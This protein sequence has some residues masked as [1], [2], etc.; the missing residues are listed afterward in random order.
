MKPN[1]KNSVETQIQYR[2][3]EKLNQANDKLK[4]EIKIRKKSER[5]LRQSEKNLQDLAKFPEENPNP[6]IRISTSGKILYANKSSK[7]LFDCWGCKTGDNCPDFLAEDLLK[8][9]GLGAQFEREI[10]V[11]DRYYSIEFAP[12]AND[13][14]VN[15][16]G[17]DISE[18]KLAEDAL[19][20]N[21]IKFRQLVEEANDIIYR[22][23]LRGTF[24]YIN[25]VA[26]HLMQID[27]KHVGK[28][29]YT[30]LIREDWKK[31]IE[32]F[33]IKQIEEDIPTTYFEFPASNMLGDQV[34]I[35]QN[36][37]I[38]K[39]RGKTTGLQAV[40]R[41]IT[42]RKNLEK[43]LKSINSFSAV[44]LK[45]NSI[46]EIVWE[47]THMVINELDFVDC[48]IYLFDESRKV[49]MQCA[50]HGPKQADQNK[51]N[52]PI[53]IPLGEGIVGTVAKTGQYELVSDTSQ[54]P[55]YIIDDQARLSELAVPI[56]TDGEVIGVIDSEHPSKDFYTIEH[57]E[58]LQTV[59]GLIA[60][61]LKN[62]I[63]QDKLNQAQTKLAKLSAAVQ[64]S[65]LATVITD[66]KGIIE[67]V[68][69]AF[70]LATGY[71]IKE[72]IGRRTNLLKSGHQQQEFYSALWNTIRKGKTWKGEMTN[73]KKNG[74]NYWVLVSISPILNTTGEITHFVAIQ[75]DIT[76]LKQLENAL[77]SAKEKAEDADKAK[78]RFLANMTHE[79]RT[80]MH[81]IL[82]MSKL[83]E[84]AK[85]SKKH[86]KYL[87]AIQTSAD[88]LLVIINDI[89]DQSKIEAGK[90][91]LEKIGFRIK[92]IE[93]SAVE[94]V[95]Y[96]A[97]EKDLFISSHMNN[98]LET[99][100]LIGDPV[101]LNQILTNLISN[102]LKFSKKGEIKLAC[103]IVDESEDQ[104][105]VRY[106]VADT[107]IGI[108]KNKL[109]TIF[110]DFQQVDDST[111]RKYGGTGLGLSICK[112]LVELQGG[113]IWVDSTE[114]KGS[115]F[116]FEISFT[117]GFRNDIMI[118]Q[119]PSLNYDIK[120]VRILLAEDHIINQVFVTSILEEQG[121]ELDIAHNGKQAIDKL[122]LKTYDIVLM[123]IQMPVMGGIEATKIIR[124]ELQLSIP[125]IAL[126]ANATKGD[127]DRYLAL[128]LNEY[129]FKPFKD[130]ELINKIGDLLN[131][132]STNEVKQYLDNFFDPKLIN[133]NGNPLFSLSKLEEMSRG[134]KD[135][136]DKMVQ[137][138]IA[139]T[140]KLLSSLNKY[141][142]N[143]EYDRV[144]SI[145]H[146]MKPS[147]GMMDMIS[148]QS[149]IQQIED[150]SSAKINLDKI[151]LLVRRV[152]DYCNTCIQQLS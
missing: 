22:I 10:K 92:D 82:G 134:N 87:N 2:M 130:T 137:L 89:L 149:D 34:W 23:N 32:E 78:S 45:K 83:L 93:K 55:R 86:Q 81:G 111:T 64:Q 90:L 145:A 8:A 112:L 101:R 72:S 13:G 84:T 144:R 17:K 77:I 108:P 56:I 53:T 40:A 5:S 79:I 88:N 85:L 20:E 138:F 36:V 132:P 16:Y 27:A 124:E 15:L 39:V 131:Q 44:I 97:S 14:Y 66:T 127:G 135:F 136:V 62:T 11:E 59:S 63:N 116:F 50:A 139:E 52:D 98:R 106:S 109:N 102:A 3:L 38:L 141:V 24:T 147:I 41:N 76:K 26:A 129:M 46:E 29:H 94:S 69:P 28:L 146:K 67:F 128:G 121:V 7:F 68:N 103:E 122:K 42:E 54:D 9:V 91:E 80:P 18:R 47:V 74:E 113:S 4:E 107:G 31:R 115:T 60:T 150:Y 104:L 70:E 75:T 133:T 105:R 142:L 35:G 25:P 143:N 12:I 65:S 19:E 118:D 33:Y 6:I 71:S 148:I 21:Q 100:V 49:L 114:G 58:K 96:L 140:P 117:K 119:V 151:P 30:K 95:E 126:T 37:N 43:Y 61:R 48:V 51:I 1:R 152:T 125:I 110:G 99:E 123:D 73:R 57:V 120:G